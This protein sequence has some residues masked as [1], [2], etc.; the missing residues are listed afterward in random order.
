MILSRLKGFGE[1][2]FQLEQYSTDADIAAEITWV[3]FYRRE[4]SGNIIADFGCGTGILGLST[5]LMGAKQVYFV[6]KDSQ[7]IETAKENMKMLESEFNVV[8]D[9]KCVF[10]IGDI[11]DFDV[12]VNVVVEN[13]PFGIQGKTHADKEF[14]Q[15]AFLTG[16]LIYSFHKSESLKFIDAVSKDNGFKINGKWDFNWPLKQT[17][18]FHTKKRQHIAVSCFRLE[19]I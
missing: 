5:L 10:I 9:D 7:A 17:M 18:K 12:K 1:P 11:K 19:K 14:L 2:K 15:K 13:P 16:E 6:D 4:I 3:M 8:L